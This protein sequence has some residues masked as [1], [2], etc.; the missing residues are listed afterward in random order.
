MD[1]VTCALLIVFS[2]CS[3]NLTENSLELVGIMGM[4]CVPMTDP[5]MH[6]VKDDWL[7]IN[8]KQ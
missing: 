5:S 1:I 2:L 6:I 8:D 4:T 7:L 3:G